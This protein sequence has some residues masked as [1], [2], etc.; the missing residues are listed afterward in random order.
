[1]DAARKTLASYAARHR[2][3]TRK[4]ELDVTGEL[5]ELTQRAAMAERDSN[6]ADLSVQIG[7]IMAKRDLA[8]A[9]PNPH[10]A[11]IDKQT[12]ELSNLEEKRLKLPSTTELP[13]SYSPLGTIYPAE[14][15]GRRL[16]Y[17]RWMTDRQNPLTARV[18]VNHI[19]RHHFG[20]PLVERVFDFGMRSPAPKNQELLDWL[21]V[22]LMNDNWS[23]KKLHRIIV[24]SAAYRRESS[25]RENTRHNLTVDRDNDWLWRMPVRRMDAEVVRDSLLYLGNYL[26]ASEGGPPLQHDQGQT[27]FRRSIYYRHDKERQ[28]TF[29]NLFDG[30]NVNECYERSHTVSPQQ[31]LA[32][33]NSQLADKLSRGLAKQVPGES[34]ADYVRNLFQHV[35]GRDPTALELSEC[36]AF[37]LDFPDREGARFQLALVLLNHNDFVT[38]R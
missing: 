24:T 21:A 11:E 8:R 12:K 31:A 9:S 19:W 16:G 33:Y 30:A 34:A 4:Y 18:A 26:D 15:S 14:S 10:K 17:A 7:D 23:M 3:E 25:L 29:L 22:R 2:A 36:S 38:I 6:V 32:M 5:I 35:I 27:T 1:L 28:M 37:C 13:K 20:S